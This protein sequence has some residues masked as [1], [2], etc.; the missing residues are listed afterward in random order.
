MQFYVSYQQTSEHH[1]LY[2]HYFPSFPKEYVDQTV[3]YEVALEWLHKTYEWKYTDQ[4]W[5]YEALPWFIQN[6]ALDHLQHRSEKGNSDQLIIGDRFKAL[7]DEIY[8]KTTAIN[9][10][11]NDWDDSNYYQF[12]Q[13]KGYSILRMFNRTLGEP[14]FQGAVKKFVAERLNKEVSLFNE[15]LVGAVDNSSKTAKEISV[16]DYIRSWQAMEKYPIINVT[17]DRE[18]GDI[19]VDHIEFSFGDEA[20][21]QSVSIP[22]YYT[23]DS[24]KNFDYMGL[25]WI[26]APY[27]ST[28]IKAALDPTVN[29]SWVVLN[30]M[31]I[32][33][34][35]DYK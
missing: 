30:P 22:I 23:N 29:E 16:S 1:I 33:K 35:L 19:T 4:Y 8:F 15:C 2:S 25:E 20:L 28:I 3:A 11:D 6:V 34:L 7:R 14:A 26:K 13:R 27:N 17:I 21:H 5:V 12:I 24:V 10:F 18:T 31:G 32:G 9:V